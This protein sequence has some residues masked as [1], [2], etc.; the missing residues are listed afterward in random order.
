MGYG[1]KCECNRAMPAEDGHGRSA[2]RP[3]AI[4]RRGWWDILKRV[5]LGISG[6]NL[7]LAAAG[8]A[9]YAFLAIP[10]AFTA[11]VAFYGIAFNPADVRGQVQAM[12]GVMPKEAIQLIS[13]QLQSLI[14]HST[15]LSI[16]FVISI[17]IALWSTQSG[18]TSMM[19]ALNMAYGA[20]EKRGLVRYYLTAFVLTLAAMIF[21]VVALALI[22]VLPAVIG[23]LPFG[24][25]DKW[26]ATIVRWPILIVL[27]LIALAVLFRYAPAREEPKWRWVS[28]GAIAAAV[29]WIVG[30]VLFSLYVE[31][32]AT[33]NKTYGSLG[34]VVVL[35]MW[36]YVSAFA[37]LLG[38]ELNA[39]I[40]RQTARD[41]TSGPERPLGQ[42]GA[43]M[44]DTLGC[45][46]RESIRK[47][48]VSAAEQGDKLAG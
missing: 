21:A 27:I 7:S 36:L 10:S 25:F 26:A 39:E 30:S 6:K 48:G 44:A 34:A 45:E 4:P 31:E 40:E 2:E 29:L 9:F 37:V 12:H 24:D 46:N 8:A 43:R 5:T 32:F 3:S 1:K 15:S 11:L 14:S 38:A 17:L 42:R 23:F 41:S 33:Y 13:T 16:G 47:C 22:A 28:W 35:M 18:T 19:S 20:K